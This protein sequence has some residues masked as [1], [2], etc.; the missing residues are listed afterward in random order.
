MKHLETTVYNDNLLPHTNE[1][2][3]KEILRLL[4]G[5]CD[6][7]KWEISAHKHYHNLHV[8]RSY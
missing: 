1:M 3:R 5:V 8:I 6:K 7:S 4:A 2:S